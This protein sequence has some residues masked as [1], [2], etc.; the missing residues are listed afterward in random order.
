MPL[1]ERRKWKTNKSAD[2]IRKIVIDNLTQKKAKIT[3]DDRSYIEARMGSGMQV[4]LWGAWL[5]KERTLPVKIILNLY[6]DKNARETTVDVTI[7]DDY[8][9]GSRTGMAGKYRLYITK[10]FED[11]ISELRGTQVDVVTTF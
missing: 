1:S 10:L 7:Q 9:F 6:R 3:Q 11:L 8:G 4:R 2:E 5:V